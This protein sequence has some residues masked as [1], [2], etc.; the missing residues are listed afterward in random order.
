MLN[1]Q[2]AY[3]WKLNVQPLGSTIDQRVV[4]PQWPLSK[5]TEKQRREPDVKL[6]W[7]K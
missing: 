7:T 3:L 5:R 6:E 2:D 4:W 1:A